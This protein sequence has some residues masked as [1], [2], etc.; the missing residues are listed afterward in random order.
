MGSTRLPGKVMADI[1]GEPMV[2]QVIARAAAAA[3]VAETVLCISGEPGDEPLAGLARHRDWKLVR[4]GMADDVLGRLW[5]AA[6]SYPDHDL[7][8][9][10][11]ADCPMLDASLIDLAA[12][13]LDDS[14]MATT[15]PTALTGWPDGLDVEVIRRDVLARAAWEATAGYDRE[16]VTPW[17]RR[18]GRVRFLSVRDV[19]LT[20]SYFANAGKWSVDTADD[21]EFVRRIYA[22]AGTGPWGYQTV[23][24]VLNECP[25]A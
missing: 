25:A 3:V 5:V 19:G 15:S 9:R 10:I 24:R 12:E 2:A 4:A 14:D 1:A 11:T 17:I 13:R 23:L 6:A 22:H 21:L 16:H 7:I 20:A 8:V 18:N